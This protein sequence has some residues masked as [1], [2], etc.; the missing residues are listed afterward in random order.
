MLLLISFAAGA[1]ASERT[2]PLWDG[3]ESVASYA[4]RTGL[5][6][7]KTIDLGSGVNLELVLIPAGRFTMGTP[8]A[9][10][11]E[12]TVRSAQIYIGVGAVLALLLLTIPLV[13][14]LRG[15]RFSF[16]LRWL[17]AFCLACSVMVWGGT[18]WHLAPIKQREYEAAME[19]SAHADDDEKPAHPVVIST[20]F[21]MGKDPITQLQYVVV[22][23][24]V[25]SGFKVPIG[26]V[27]NISWG[28][29]VA[30]CEKARANSGARL[31][32]P[33]EAEWEY[34]C[35]AGTQT[36]F[37]TGDTSVIYDPNGFKLIEPNTFGLRNMHGNIWEWC[38]DY[39]GQ[40]KDDGQE[41][42]P[43]GPDHGSFRVLRG[44]VMGQ[45]ERRRRSAARNRTSPGNGVY[46]TGFRVCL[47][48]E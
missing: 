43:R 46:P 36:E 34:A 10:P 29:A 22:T 12:I 14:K 27:H 39:Y 16:S 47:P 35:R 4:A 24:G 41:Y 7:E 44:S 26:A 18:R 42:D 33:T 6:P 13:R 3:R 25:P 23:R 8:E 1:T 15:R 9:S 11:P 37:S 28:D 17:M 30:F 19:L 20:P 32:L 2:Y 31:R 48:V 45:D 38:H 5:A 21:F 40:Y